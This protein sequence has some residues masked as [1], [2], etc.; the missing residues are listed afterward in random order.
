MP[1]FRDCQRGPGLYVLIAITYFEKNLKVIGWGVMVVYIKIL[2]LGQ[3]SSTMAHGDIA[4]SVFRDFSRAVDA[5][6]ASRVRGPDQRP[7]RDGVALQA[8]QVG[9]DQELAVVVG[10][11][12]R[13]QQG[14]QRI[15]RSGGRQRGP[16]QE[17]GRYARR[18]R[19]ESQQRR[20]AEPAEDTRVKVDA[21]A[22]KDVHVCEYNDSVDVAAGHGAGDCRQCRPC[23]NRSRGRRGPVLEDI[24]RFRNG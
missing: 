11:G 18:V 23:S 3:T 7:I 5:R 19:A 13:A 2:A 22:E 8:E 15:G 10:F 9:R 17:V 14:G 24:T 6:H 21:R 4:H 20:T 1:N 16:G 12:G